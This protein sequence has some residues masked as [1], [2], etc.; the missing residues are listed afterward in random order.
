MLCACLFTT[1]TSSWVHHYVGFF[2][3]CYQSFLTSLLSDMSNT[4]PSLCLFP[5]ALNSVFRPLTFNLYVS[6]D[7]KWVSCREYILQ[8]LVF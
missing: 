4:T 2:V 6:L 8:V 7:L 1:A 3:F 5:F